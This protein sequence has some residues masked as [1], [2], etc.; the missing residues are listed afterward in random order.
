[1]YVLIQLDP[2][3][4]RSVCLGV[5]KKSE[6]TIHDVMQEASD[7]IRRNKLD[8][9]KLRFSTV[10]Q[11]DAAFSKDDRRKS[12]MYMDAYY[13]DGKILSYWLLPVDSNNVEM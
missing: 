4:H 13:E 5:Y 9:S 6:Q 8:I 11:M 3:T 1:M 7:Y 12:N 2:N 10:Y